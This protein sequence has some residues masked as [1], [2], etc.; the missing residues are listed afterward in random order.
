[1]TLTGRDP[2]RIAKTLRD[3]ADRRVMLRVSSGA[4]RTVS[5]TMLT[6]AADE[7]DRLRLYL[8]DTAGRLRQ[9]ANDY[10]ALCADDM[11]ELADDM[12]AMANRG[13]DE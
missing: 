2:E 1:M 12:E 9:L 5:A 4:A 8:L 3:V 11:R 7:M 13:D 6:V 10:H